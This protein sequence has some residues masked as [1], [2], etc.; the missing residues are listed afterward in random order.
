MK[1]DA[2]KWCY[3]IN[4]TEELWISKFSKIHTLHLWHT[5]ICV[6]ILDTENKWM[7]EWMKGWMA[8]FVKSMNSRKCFELIG[9]SIIWK[10]VNTVI[11][12]VRHL[13]FVYLWMKINSLIIFST[14]SNAIYIV[15]RILYIY[16]HWK[17]YKYMFSPCS[18]TF[19]WFDW[20]TQT[21]THTMTFPS[22]IKWSTFKQIFMQ[23]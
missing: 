17:G 21:H 16:S 13:V 20:E 15:P 23:T 7:N 1:L 2:I 18:S 10:A 9:Y 19:N 8:I 14:E 3:S 12:V 4:R 22:N 5:N 6:N 11:K